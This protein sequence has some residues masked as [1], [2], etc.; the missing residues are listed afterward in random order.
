M[1]YY[2]YTDLEIT[3]SI[4]PRYMHLLIE[5]NSAGTLYTVDINNH[6]IV[7][8]TTDKGANWTTVET[9]TAGHAIISAWHDRANEV[10]YFVERDATSDGIVCFQLDYGSSDTITE[11]GSIPTGG[12]GEIFNPMDLFMISTNLYVSI[13][14]DDGGGNK[15][16]EIY[17]W[18]DPNWV[19]DATWV[20]A[21]TSQA[22]GYVA[23]IGSLAYMIGFDYT[24]FNGDIHVLVYSD[25]GNSLTSLEQV[26][27]N[28]DK[29]LANTQYRAL[30]YD[31][32]DVLY[33]ILWDK[34]ESKYYL[35]YYS[36][37][38]DTAT[39][40]G[41]Y[42]VC[43]MLD[44]NTNGVQEKAFHATEYK[45]YQIQ[46]NK[47]QLNLIST[48]STDAV[49]FSI[50]DTFLMNNDG[51]MF[52]YE[53][54]TDLFSSILID[55]QIQD[56]SYAVVTII[57]DT[58]PIALNMMMKFY[59]NYT[60]GGSTSEDIIFEG[61]VIKFTDMSMQTITLVSPA[62]KEISKI[63]PNGDYTVDSDG[64]L[65]SLITDHN[66][67][68]TAGTLTDGADLGTITLAGDV[69]EGLVF[70]STAQFEGW[71]WYLNPTG[72]L[73][74]N[75]GTIDSGVDYSSAS[76]L[77]GVGSEYIHDIY[78][79]LKIRGAYVNSVQVESDW[80]E[81]TESQQTLGVNERIITIHFLNTAALCNTAA[82]NLITIL[83]KNP[84][85]VSFSVFDTTKGYIQVGETIT[86]E[87]TG[88]SVTVASDQFLI[89]S[90]TINKYGLI[91]YT[92]ISELS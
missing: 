43:L 1:K 47:V 38:N 13:S 44:R 34:G 31:G 49:F 86:F 32:N 29:Q 10:I 6:N 90:A 2:N 7:A 76:V 72:Q 91:R 35:Y 53:D 80:Y 22:A 21:R 40:L 19:L 73:F 52:E 30:P 50:T 69:S 17:K 54:K 18:V 64:L 24:G 37:T 51:D 81:D 8:K 41:E 5:T 23:V 82:S 71:I 88:G 15:T 20:G 61:V 87:C 11:F 60:T 4:K 70:D 65:T 12:G 63:F 28:D 39:Q 67:Y 59:H 3:S 92:G 62:K 68:I 84:Q 78:N 25:A 55:H 42:N 75:N 16:L 58:I 36:I 74:F 45:I 14:H 89:T 48:P 46:E 56:A 77:R 26:T 9:R 57:K 66:S 33:W 85:K 27:N 83:A 79:K